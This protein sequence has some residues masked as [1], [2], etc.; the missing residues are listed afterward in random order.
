MEILVMATLPIFNPTQFIPGDA[1]DNPYHP[2]KPGTSYLYGGVKKDPE[3]GEGDR[4]TSKLSVTFQT[5]NVAGVAANVIKDTAWTNGVLQEDTFD[6]F[7]QDKEGNVWYLGEATTEYKYDDEGNFIGTNNKGSWEAGVDGALPGHIM[8]AKP[9][10]GDNYYQEFAQKQGAVDQATVNGLNKT[11]STKLGTFNNVLQT[12]EFTELQ[13]GAAEFKYYAPGVGLVL[14]DEGL[15]QNLK[16][17]F[18]PELLS[19]SNVTPDAFT[20]G[21]GTLENDSL[22]G[23]NG[24]NNLKGYRGHDLLQGFDGDDGLTGHDGNDFLVGGNGL[25]SLKGGNGRDILIGGAGAD[26]LRGD[27]GRDQF[28]FRT[29]AD[30]G[31]LI[32]DFTRQDVIVLVEIFKLDNYASSNPFD[33]YLKITQAGS[34]TVVRI[35]ADGNLGSKPFEVLAVLKNTRA[36]SLSEANFVL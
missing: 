20:S 35:D 5:K 28:V 1:I 17:E 16:P 6:W 29:L 14:I 23:D 3:T 33:D 8:K 7:A 13:P 30:K 22:D 26:V 27:K 2:L 9:Q 31:D 11:I 12:L 21:Q 34:R 18:S 36:N 25:D 15:D 4:E 19:V 24:S 32:K 10:V